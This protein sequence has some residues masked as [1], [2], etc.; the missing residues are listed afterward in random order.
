MFHK[1]LLGSCT[2]TRLHEWVAGRRGDA[3]LVVLV[4]GHHDVAL[5]S[6]ASTPGVLDEPVVLALVSSIPDYQHSMV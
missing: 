6:P 5:H 3:A 4:S 1:E 2:I